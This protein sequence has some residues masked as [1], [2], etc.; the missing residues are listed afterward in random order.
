MFLSPEDIKKVTDSKGI[1]LE[2]EGNRF[3]YLFERENG[4]KAFLRIYD[5]NQ[6]DPRE[7]EITAA[8]KTM[9]VKSPQVAFITGH[10]ERDIYKGGERDYSAFAKISLSDIL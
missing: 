8:L 10:G 7:S 6:R 4:Q 3:V 1:N 9:V 5:D 2:E